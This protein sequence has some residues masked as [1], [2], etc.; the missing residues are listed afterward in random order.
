MAD[1]MYRNND[2]LGGATYVGT[3]AAFA[4]ELGEFLRGCYRDR[5]PEDA[6]YDPDITRE[7]WIESALDEG[8]VEADAADLARLPRLVVHSAAVALG[9]R[10]GAAA[11]PAQA[12]A[13]RRNGLRGGRPRT[14][15][16]WA[17]AR[18]DG[19]DAGLVCCDL[20]KDG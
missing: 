10:G 1:T 19:K 6:D 15:I 7:D 9:R 20:T 3:R 2:T 8:L 18:I 13:G 5:D 12:E 11:T 14:T 4:R 17:V 16:W